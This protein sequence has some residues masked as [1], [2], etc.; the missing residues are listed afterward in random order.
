MHGIS[1]REPFI[2]TILSLLP[3]DRGE[4]SITALHVQ[5]SVGRSFIAIVV[6]S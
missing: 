3:N 6:N 2:R 5:V 1:V 4:K